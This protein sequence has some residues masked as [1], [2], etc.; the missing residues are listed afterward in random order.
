M[1]IIKKTRLIIDKLDEQMSYL[2]NSE[3][4]EYFPKN[5]NKE[6]GEKIIFTQ[7]LV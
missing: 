3:P 4:S 7:V 6:I 2:Q 5:G 1:K